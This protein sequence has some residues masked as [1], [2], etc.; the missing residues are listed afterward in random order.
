M[1]KYFMLFIVYFSVSVSHAATYQVLRGTLMSDGTIPLV[2]IAG[3]GSFTEGVFDGSATQCCSSLIDVSATNTGLQSF[4]VLNG[5]AETY[6]ASS[7]V[8]GGVHSAPTIDL[9]S[10][11]ADLSSFYINWNGNEIYMGD[12]AM[13]SD[14][15]SG[16]YELSWSVSD[17]ALSA[18]IPTIFDLTMQVSAVPVPAAIWLFGSGLLG[19][20]AFSRRRKKP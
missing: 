10:M 19:L 7:G 4:V 16:V 3:G 15:G 9:S 8:D 20:V 11:T 1:M 14:L 17:G 2:E 13:V 6:F 12:V 5:N 18:N